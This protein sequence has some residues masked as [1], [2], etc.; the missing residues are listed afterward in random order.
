MKQ[1]RRAERILGRLSRIRISLRWKLLALFIIAV[2]PSLVFA[3]IAF[4]VIGRTLSSQIEGYQQAVVEGAQMLA[5]HYALNCQKNLVTLGGERAFRAAVADGD[6][7]RVRSG[8]QRVYSR[9]R[10]YSFLS[11]AYRDQAGRLKMLASYPSDSYLRMTDD[12]DIYSFLEKNF[13]QPM[14][15]ISDVYTFRGKREILVTAPIRGAVIIGGIDIANLHDAVSRIKP[16]DEGSI[17]LAD[18]TRSIITP[19]EEDF[20]EELTGKTGHVRFN[21]GRTIA[22]YKQ[23]Q[24]TGWWT[25]LISPYRAIYRSMIYMRILTFILIGL[26]LF[27]ALYLALYFSGRVT[28]PILELIRGARILGEGNLGYRIRMNSG[29]ELEQLAD[30]FNRMGEHL[31]KTYEMM[32]GKIQN[33]TRD[34]QNAFT[35]IEAM[36]TQLKRADTLKSEFLAS[37]SHEL[38]TPMNAIIGFTA[39]LKDGTYGKVSTKQRDILGKVIKSTRHLL[40][41]INDILDLSKIEAGRMEFIPEKFKLKLLIEEIRDETAPLAQEKGL[42]FTVSVPDEIEFFQDY[43][44]VRQIIMNL[45]S[46][47]VKFTEE[48]GISIRARYEGSDVSISVKDT[49]I[50]IREED[51]GHIFNEFVQADGSITRE[52]GGTGLGLSIVRKLTGLMGGRVN[53]ESK[54]GEGTVFTVSLP[55]RSADSK[56]GT[57]ETSD[58]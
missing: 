50:G 56:E 1:E 51:M 26:G 46:N 21:N 42:E 3:A 28:V 30:E 38:R 40:N 24:E 12:P 23:N 8:L 47:A 37:M 25:V 45:V 16:A 34:L 13:T 9:S 48:G 10:I 4:T 17:V 18:G 15:R 36:N 44:R 19:A 5:E 14:S 20:S 7:R 11:V 32:E 29:D 52:F 53:V 22:Y 49:G 35:E 41:L 33:A 55:P 54:W 27:A 2:I 43:T 39:L 6:V 57:D 31:Q 58:S